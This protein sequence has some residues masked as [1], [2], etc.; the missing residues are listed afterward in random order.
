L[1]DAVRQGRHQE[2]EQAY[3]EF[4]EAIPDPLA[5][6]TFLSAILDWNGRWQPEGKRRFAHVRAL[7]ATRRR[8]IVPHL[9]GAAFGSARCEEGATLSASWSLDQGK[10]LILLAN[11]SSEARERPREIRSG[12]PIWGGDPS[13]QLPGW[14]V[15]W[16]IGDA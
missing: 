12:R 9:H 4:G 5:E 2:F 10:S 8:E 3:A 11:L 14:S 15:F 6:A 13:S 16:S 1:A 7:L